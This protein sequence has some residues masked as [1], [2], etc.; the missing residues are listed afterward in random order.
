[1]YQQYLLAPVLFSFPF[2]GSKGWAQSCCIS[3]ALQS[4]SLVI[5]GPQ[6]SGFHPTSCSEPCQHEE[7]KDFGPVVCLGQIGAWSDQV[8]AQIFIC[9]SDSCQGNTSSA[10]GEFDVSVTLWH[11]DKCQTFPFTF[12]EQSQPY[13]STSLGINDCLICKIAEK[14]VSYWWDSHKVAERDF[15]AT[16]EATLSP[17]CPKPSLA[18]IPSSAADVGQWK[19]LFQAELATL[20]R[21]NFLG[22]GP[23]CTTQES[24]AHR[25]ISQKPT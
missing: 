12:P 7:R 1:M 21:R 5:S 8:S 10:P 20:S 9:F 18:D 24:S 14:S 13:P 6:I 11:P 17:L 3:T 4:L 2:H 23:S 22:L 16:R 15:R 25:Q 19:H